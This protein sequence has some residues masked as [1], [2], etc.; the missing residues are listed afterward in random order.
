MRMGDARFVTVLVVLLLAACG[1]KPAAPAPPKPAASAEQPQP[2]TA[3]P[4]AGSET[5]AAETDAAKTVAAEK[6]PELELPEDYQ[7]LL[8]PR[9]DDLAGMAKSRYVRVLVV[10]SKL[11]YFVD[12][13]RQ[14]GI[15]YETLQ[16]FEQHLNRK[17]KTKTLKI[18]V[19]PI[20]VARDQLLPALVSG[21][22]DIAA[23]GLTVT[24]ARRAQVDF[25]NPFAEDV[26]EIVIT[27]PSAPAVASVDDLSGKTVW[28]RR[29]SSYF[30]HLTAL[31]DGFKRAGKALVDIKA[32]DE[33]LEDEDLIEMVAAGV[34]PMT[35]AD[36]YLA[37]FWSQVFEQ[38][39]P[40]PDLAIH[41][42]SQIA[43]ALRKNTP[44]LAKSVNEFVRT[45]RSGTRSGNVLLFKY[46]KSTK[47]V[48]NAIADEEVSKLR[49]M[50]ELFQTYSDR[51]SFDW[52]MVAAQAYQESGLDQK[53]R[54]HVGAVGVMQVMPTTAADKRVNIKGIDKLEQNIHAGTK[55]LRLLADDYF[56]DPAIDER[57]RM[58]FCFA[59]YNAGPNRVQSLRRQ[60]AKQGLDPNKWFQNVEIVA[61]RRIGR[62]TVQYV[63]N[64]YK[65]YLAYQ[66]IYESRELKREAQKKLTT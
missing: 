39:K 19:V 8:Q 36:S 34:L 63:S 16:A 1:D 56:S 7:S 52:L 53:R 35:V 57:N 5:D 58:L 15:T 41:V 13:G 50:L 20:P 24:A 66:M 48:R 27:G 14:Q 3:P 54:S 32:A 29:S 47:W 25:A 12:E 65:Y 42:G 49:P 38:A 62:E 40:R 33:N 64:I 22:G 6:P 21:R 23:A 46:L 44:E 10:H 2:Q 43:W 11:F 17:L 60:A 18:H 31:N 28:V 61:A 51:Y 9:F 45:H 55:Y 59:A 30:E 37:N 4:A 26:Q